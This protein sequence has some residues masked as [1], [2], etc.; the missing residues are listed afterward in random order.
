MN[1]PHVHLIGNLVNDPESRY[2]ASDGSPYTTVRVACNTFN[3]DEETRETHFFSVTLWGRQGIR[4]KENAKK[5]DQVVVFGRMSHQEYLKSDGSPGCA[6][7][8]SGKEFRIVGRAHAQ[9]QT[10]FERDEALRDIEENDQEDQ[11]DP[12]GR[13][14]EPPF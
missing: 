5:G 4:A 1:G 13:E 9:Q 2:A 6:L 12:E 7:S 11:P 10:D 14:E 3:R 8:I